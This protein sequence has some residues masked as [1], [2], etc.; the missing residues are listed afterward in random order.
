MRSSPDIRPLVS[1]GMPVY[2]GEQ[3]VAEAIESMLSQNYSNIELIISDNASTDST[4]NVCLQFA[5]QDSRV[6]FIEQ[7]ENL[8]QIVN[9]RAVFNASRGKYFAWAGH[10]DIWHPEWIEAN[11]DVLER[12]PE[13]VLAYPRSSA[14]SNEGEELPSVV[15]DFESFGMAKRQRIAETCANLVG[16]GNR[17]YGLMR[18]EA[19]RKTPVYPYFVGPDRLLLMELAVHGTFKQIERTLWYRRY[20]DGESTPELGVPTDYQSVI[21]DYQKRLFNPEHGYPWHSNFPVL[22]HIVGLIYHLSINPPDKNYRNALWGFYMAK[23]YFLRRKN[24]VFKEIQ[25][26]MRRWFSG[27]RRPTV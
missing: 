24:F 1:I 27:G 10:H 11:L 16:A 22:G 18:S 7:A 4:A 17:V 21:D 25:M 6:T 5:K 14:I 3:H 2:N 19:L 13:V 20:D 23:L 26:A 9:F 12:H 8:G 15:Q